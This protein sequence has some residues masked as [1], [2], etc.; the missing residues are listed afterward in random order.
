MG[1]WSAGLS[2][3]VLALAAPLLAV[4]EGNLR[5]AELVNPWPGGVDWALAAALYASVPVA[6]A[7]LAFLPEPAATPPA[8]RPV[9]WLQTARLGEGVVVLAILLGWAAVWLTFDRR[10]KLLAEMDY[11]ASCVQ[12]EAVLAAAKEVKALNDPAKIRL[13]LALYHTGR[14][15]EELFSF[16]NLIEEA[17]SECRRGLSGAKPT[18]LRTRFGQRRRAHGVRGPCDG[19]RPS[20]S[21]ATVG[22]HQPGERPTPGGAGLPERAEPDTVPG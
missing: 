3:L 20:R 18:P 16:H 11:D 13:E 10:Q 7:V 12:Y 17:P 14:L 4:G 8:P 1:S 2:C 15:A 5:I 19:G 21:I 9:R 22:A 6:G